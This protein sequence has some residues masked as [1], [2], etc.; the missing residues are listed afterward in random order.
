MDDFEESSLPYFVDIVDP[1]H[2]TSPD[3]ID[4]IARVGQVIYE[5]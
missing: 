5:R 2:C 3:L 4:H 1:A